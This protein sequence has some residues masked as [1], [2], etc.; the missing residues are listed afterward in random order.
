MGFA[1]QARQT[2]GAPG[3]VAKTGRGTSAFALCG[4]LW[5]ASGATT[6]PA[7]S[8]NAAETL[9]QAA[10]RSSLLMG[11]AADSDFL[12]EP[13][14]SSTLASQYAQLEPENAM[15]FGTIHPEPGTYDFAEADKLVA[16]AQAHFMKVRGHNLVW[17]Q[18]VPDWVI[19]PRVP[20][21]PSTLNR[22]LA[23]HIANVVGRYKSKV[24][25]WDV[26]NEPFNDDG[27]LRSAV[28]FNQPG[29]GF[30]GQGT[31]TIEQALRW[32]H[33]ADPEAR[34]FVNE[35]G[36]ET[37][38]R[39]SDHLYAMAKDFVKRGVPL[40][41]IGLELHVSTGIDQPG[42]LASI[43]RN[44]QRLAALGLEVQFTEVDVRLQDGS[45]SSL[46]KQAQMYKD[47]LALCLRQPACT[48]FQTWGFTDKYSWIPTTFSGY[49]WALPFN[50]SFEKK[51]A[52]Y[53]LLKELH[54][55]EGGRPRLRPSR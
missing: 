2:R 14:Y 43:S 34:L 22:M 20:W 51:P 35:I 31:R 8:P 27:T 46:N 53:A 39:K 36:A 7:Q 28:W 45:A 12:S 52:F 55:P 37:L 15:K 4:L 5:Q 49:G 33:A 26:V 13:L 42:S 32:A 38:N 48:A 29:I 44:I 9:R 17:Y 1:G 6:A 24:Y 25:A 40:S 23:D 11:A 30:A 47:L 41:G 3:I 54:S 19:K 16:F 10:Q 18:Q 21:T 50:Q